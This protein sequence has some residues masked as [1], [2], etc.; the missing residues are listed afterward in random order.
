MELSIV[1]AVLEGSLVAMQHISSLHDVQ[2]WTALF[3]S[4]SMANHPSWCTPARPVPPTPAPTQYDLD[5][6]TQLFMDSLD[7]A[8]NHTQVQIGV[9]LDEGEFSFELVR[10]NEALQAQLSKACDEINVLKL[11]V[12]R[13]CVSVDTPSPSQLCSFCLVCGRGPR[14]MSR[15]C[16]GRCGYSHA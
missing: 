12:T 9:D 1:C 14:L 16:R 8:P 10:Y 2:T 15:T 11:L 5:A 7:D 3:V 13:L 6:E 4:L